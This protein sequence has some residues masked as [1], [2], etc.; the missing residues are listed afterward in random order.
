[1]NGVKIKDLLNIYDLEIR[2][3]TK[4]KRKVFAFERNKMQNIESIYNSLID[5]S[6]YQGTKIQNSYVFKYKR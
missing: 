4:N 3:N 2:I 5:N 1:M 6:Y